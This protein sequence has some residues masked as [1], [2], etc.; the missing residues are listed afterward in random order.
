MALP[1]YNKKKSR[2]AIQRARKHFRAKPDL[3]QFGCAHLFFLSFDISLSHC[4]SCWL[5]VAGRGA[6]RREEGLKLKLG[7]EKRGEASRRRQR[8]EGIQPRAMPEY[9]N[10]A[11]SPF[12]LSPLS[13][14]VCLF[15]CLSVFV[16]LFLFSPLRSNRSVGSLDADG[17]GYTVTSSW[18]NPLKERKRKKP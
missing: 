2:S 14:F 6:R 17:R 11:S 16:Y 8:E 5:L 4:L 3:S 13:H 7:E 1:T 9:K 18:R 15:V 10:M 12:S